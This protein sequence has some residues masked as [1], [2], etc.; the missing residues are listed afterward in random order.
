MF[1][2]WLGIPPC[3]FHEKKFS[4]VKRTPAEFLHGKIS[5][6]DIYKSSC[7]R[8]IIYTLWLFAKRDY[9]RLIASLIGAIDSIRPS[10]C[11]NSLYNSWAWEHSV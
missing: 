3:I 5:S 7:Q 8:I 11:L 9:S 10:M 1:F 4:S 6:G 2:A